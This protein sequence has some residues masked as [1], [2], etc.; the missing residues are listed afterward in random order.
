MPVYAAHAGNVLT[1]AIK[2]FWG[3]SIFWAIDMLESPIPINALDA[4]GV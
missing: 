2:E 4:S 1:R 3:K